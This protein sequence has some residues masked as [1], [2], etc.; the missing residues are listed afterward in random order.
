MAAFARRA[1]AMALEDRSSA[2]Q[3]DGWTFFDRGLID[4]AAGLQHVT[5]EPI[6]EDIGRTH[7]YHRRVFLAPP[8][9]EIYRNDGERRHDLKAAEA[10]YTRL[11]H[12][13]PALGY[14]VVILPKIP[15]EARADF[16]I[17]ILADLTGR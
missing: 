4:A 8:W 13:Y 9:P 1:L 15:V 2:H 11:L 12:V 3:Q 10:E 6:L 7:R 17:D 14:E 5:G 16:V